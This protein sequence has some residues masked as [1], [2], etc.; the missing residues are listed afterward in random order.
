MSQYF[1]ERFETSGVCVK[2]ELDHATKVDIR[3]PTSIDTY[4]LASKTDLA[5][6]KT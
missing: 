5:N 6:L 2:I 3:R 1:S 4:T